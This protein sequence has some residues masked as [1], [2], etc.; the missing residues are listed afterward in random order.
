MADIQKGKFDIEWGAS[1][2]EDVTN[3]EYD[4]EVETEDF[5]TLGKQTYEV[6]GPQKIVATIELL[7]TDIPALAAVLPQYYVANGEEM[8]TGETVDD[9]DGAIDVVDNC[10]NEPVY[11]D[12]KVTSCGDP[13][14]TVRMVN[15]RTRL[16][17]INNPNTARTV[18]VRFIG[19][20]AP[21]EATV[22]FF[23]E[24]A[25]GPIS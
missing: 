13:G 17:G 2:L 3:I 25:L 21:D 11:N 19:E 1:V 6:D 23:N 18:L 5:Q 10:A 22:Q 8:S 16:D 14:Q 12:L 20:P 15:V 4:Y 7:K 24:G 9:P